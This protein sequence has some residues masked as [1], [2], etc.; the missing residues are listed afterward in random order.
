MEAGSGTLRRFEAEF[1]PEEKSCTQPGCN[2]ERRLEEL[3]EE[4][5][6]LPGEIEA[7]AKDCESEKTRGATSGR[8][9]G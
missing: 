5:K 4:L 6:R 3:R 1:K 7:F 9:A 8:S 2:H